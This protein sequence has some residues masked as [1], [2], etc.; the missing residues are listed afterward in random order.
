MHYL[1]STEHFPQYWWYPSNS[2]EHPPKHL[3]YS[4]TAMMALP[5]STDHPPQH[6][7]ARSPNR[8][9]KLKLQVYL[10]FLYP[11]G[12]KQQ[13]LRVRVLLQVLLWDTAH[14][15]MERGQIK[16][17]Q[18]CNR[19]MC[20]IWIRRGIYNANLINNSRLNLPGRYFQSFLQVVIRFQNYAAMKEKL[21]G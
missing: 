14:L 21:M 7:A 6:S 8:L 4:L 19:G 11:F 15:N 1:H 18:F 12:S 9:Y 3:W 16:M 2:T 10:T 13:E 17:A 20:S 5:N